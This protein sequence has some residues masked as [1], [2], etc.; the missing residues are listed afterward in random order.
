[1]PTLP[2]ATQ[3]NES[4]RISQNGNHGFQEDMNVTGGKW[5]DEEERRFYE[6]CQDLR[7]YVPKSVLGLESESEDASEAAAA[8]SLKENEEERKQRDA[9]EAKE[10]RNELE[11]LEL[12]DSNSKHYPSADTT[13]SPNGGEER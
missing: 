1:M 11:R 5:E 9:V 8:L 7:D 4:I 13:E 2:T 12:S 10:L 6:E 3:K